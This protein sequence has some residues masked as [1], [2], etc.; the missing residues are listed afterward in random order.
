MKLKNQMCCKNFNSLTLV[1]IK[2]KIYNTM[3]SYL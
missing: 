1:Q 2:F 3:H